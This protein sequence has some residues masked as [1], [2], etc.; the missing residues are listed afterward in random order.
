MK[1]LDGKTS[2][3]QLL[4]IQQRQNA[5]SPITYVDFLGFLFFFM[6][7]EESSLS[8]FL[9]TIWFEMSE[10]LVTESSLI[11]LAETLW[12]PLED[13]KAVQA[14]KGSSCSSY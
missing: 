11:S 2:F 13:R 8:E 5:D 7:I 1:R 10:E 4:E 12:S 3:L 9:F 14:G 6:T